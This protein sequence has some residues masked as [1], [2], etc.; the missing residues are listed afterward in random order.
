MKF[1]VWLRRKCVEAGYQNIRLLGRSVIAKP[2]EA[3]DYV[4]VA[5]CQS[6]VDYFRLLE[7]IAGLTS[8]MQQRFITAGGVKWGESVFFDLIECKSHPGAAAGG[9][10]AVTEEV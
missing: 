4:I 7:V 5:E 2:A 1:L 8:G 6:Q 9:N 10:H 3:S